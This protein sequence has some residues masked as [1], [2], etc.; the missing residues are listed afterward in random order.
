MGCSNRP[1]LDWSS[2]RGSFGDRPLLQGRCETSGVVFSSPIAECQCGKVFRVARARAWAAER[3]SRGARARECLCRCA[4][5]QYNQ[6]ARSGKKRG[7]MKRI[8]ITAAV[9]FVALA[10]LTFIA[11]GGESTQSQPAPTPCVLRD[12]DGQRNFEGGETLDGLKL[13]LETG[14][15]TQVS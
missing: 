1:C 8:A 4:G 3:S 5:E 6:A 7:N 13:N 14:E 2:R 9:A 12:A 15:W 10:G 11:R